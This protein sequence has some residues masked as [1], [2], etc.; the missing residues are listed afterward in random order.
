M[1]FSG[2][3]D[4]DVLSTCGALLS[5]VIVGLSAV[6]CCMELS[7]ALLPLPAFMFG[8]FDADEI[9]EHGFGDT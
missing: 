5:F 2:A 9:F 6:P 3:D 8:E 4:F 7:R 1:A